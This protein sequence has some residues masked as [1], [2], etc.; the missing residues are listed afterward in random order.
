M[1]NTMLRIDLDHLILCFYIGPHILK[2]ASV[3]LKFYLLPLF[4]VD[5]K[6]LLPVDRLGLPHLLEL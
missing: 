1:I 5:I 2:D 4:V 3:W 6:L